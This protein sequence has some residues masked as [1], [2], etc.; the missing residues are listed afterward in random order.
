[1]K[2]FV[3]AKEKTMVNSLVAKG[4][5]YGDRLALDV[6]GIQ[7]NAENGRTDIYF[8]SNVFYLECFNILSKTAKILGDEKEIE[9]Y[10]KKYKNLLANM[11]KE[12]FT[13]SGRLA[14]DTATAQVLAL[15]F[16]IVQEKHRKELAKKLNENVENHRFRVSTGFADT[17]FY[18]QR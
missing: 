5:E 11:R 7:K 9:I 14:V 6:D 16:N 4:Y 17:A 13:R 8:I 3:A 1:M 15:H 2:K 18:F 10:L 12:Y